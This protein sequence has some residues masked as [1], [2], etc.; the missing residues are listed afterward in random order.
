[1]SSI[2]PNFQALLFFALAW[3]LV[4]FGSFLMAGML[5]LGA[6]PKEI[7]QPTGVLLLALNAA[8]TLILAGFA[9]RLSYHD[10]RWTSVVIAGGSIFLLAPFLVQDLPDA[11]KNG[12]KGLL[13]LL[14]L[15]LCAIAPLAQF[16]LPIRL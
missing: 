9:I 11:I 6:A 12:R 16:T 4:C 1:M 5:P 14:A 3:M 13:L 7:R 10:L 2:E 15:L 8:L